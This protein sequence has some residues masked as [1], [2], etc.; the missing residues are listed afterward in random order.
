MTRVLV[1]LALVLTFLVLVSPVVLRLG[2]AG[3]APGGRWEWEVRVLGLA[4]PGRRLR[5]LAARWLRR[6]GTRVR[7]PRLPRRGHPRAKPG[8]AATAW[9]ALL[10]AY[11]AARFY[12]RALSYLARHTRVEQ[13]RWETR[14]GAGDPC[15]T[16]ILAGVLWA[17]KG[18]VAGYL[19][20]RD[21]TGVYYLVRPDFDRP[22][23][24]VD[25]R[26]SLR[27]RVYHLLAAGFLALAAALRAGS[28][29][30]PGRSR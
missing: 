11:R 12:R 3:P 30:R 1:V 26:V 17:C 9:G 6:R 8:R 14:V 5:A 18:T 13:L 2:Y 4:W 21:R 22:V 25:L 23:L 24:R 19:R 16:G 28:F 29:R 20:A 15:R 27:I 7:G 10:R